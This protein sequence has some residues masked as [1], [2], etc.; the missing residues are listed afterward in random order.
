MTQSLTCSYIYVVELHYESSNSSVLLDY[1]IIPYS[2]CN[3]IECNTS[4]TV[5]TDLGDSAVLHV[6]V[7]S[8]DSILKYN[9]TIVPFPEAGG[10]LN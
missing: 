7:L 8:S 4:I 9:S 5:Q 1:H 6:K 2:H 3:G 10:L